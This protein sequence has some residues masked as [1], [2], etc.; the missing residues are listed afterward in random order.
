MSQTA[1][2]R[3]ASDASTPDAASSVTPETVVALFGDGYTRDILAAIRDEPRPAREIAAECDMS[4]PTVY[5]RLERLEAAGLVTEQRRLGE[6]GHHC[7]LFR[8]AVE[9]VGLELGTDGF[10]VEVTASTRAD[11]G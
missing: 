5:R 8:A 1:P 4:R 2:D 3:H 10:E 11:G 9:S 7:R 6:S